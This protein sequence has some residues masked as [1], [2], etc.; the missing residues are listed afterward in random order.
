[1][2]HF[3]HSPRPP[4]PD[5][6]PIAA[7]PKRKPP[8]PPAKVPR[9]SLNDTV[10][11]CSTTDKTVVP[12]ESNTK[13]GKEEVCQSQKENPAS[14]CIKDENKKSEEEKSLP[15]KSLPPLP[16]SPPPKARLARSISS[17]KSP[18]SNSKNFISPS[19]SQ[20]SLQ[21]I[22]S[23]STPSLSPTA[24]PSHNDFAFSISTQECILSV[25]TSLSEE[26][27]CLLAS[28]SRATNPPKSQLTSCQEEYQST[29]HY[30]IT[31]QNDSSKSHTLSP[32]PLSFNAQNSISK[33]IPQAKSDGIESSSISSQRKAPPPI[34]RKSPK[35]DIVSSDEGSLNDTAAPL[36]TTRQNSEKS[37]TSSQSPA[38]TALPAK[39]E[40]SAQQEPS[41]PLPSV[42]RSLSSSSTCTSVLAN[43]CLGQD[44]LDNESNKAKDTGEHHT[45]HIGR[46]LRGECFLNYYFRNNFN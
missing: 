15:G 16:F 23:S 31:P 12:S 30:A 36:S 46:L 13:Q 7:K 28:N 22:S 2:K 11:K 4:A 3:R 5:K 27:N 39:T 42:R 14:L 17:S 38:H 44:E 37:Q 6:P 40:L 25:D 26:N 1:M 18:S 8:P 41:V 20:N 24:I 10:S 32:S 9:S 43:S 33:E 29:H 19:D 35:R 45:R 21:S 34:P